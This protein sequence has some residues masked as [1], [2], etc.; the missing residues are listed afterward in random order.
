MAK[1][2]SSYTPRF[3][4]PEPELGAFR[5]RPN[6][7][8]EYRQSLV[9]EP[10]PHVLNERHDLLQESH[11]NLQEHRRN[12]EPQGFGDPGPRRPFAEDNELAYLRARV[13]RQEAELRR[14]RLLDPGPEFVPRENRRLESLT[15]HRNDRHNYPE[16]R[17]LESLRYNYPIPINYVPDERRPRNLRS[18]EIIM[19]DP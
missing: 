7:L 10:R 16:N 4:Q 14:S 11:R 3:P 17:R 19:F 5:E 2:G 18:A 6:P 1:A 8:Q 12:S 9:P 13:T 15:G